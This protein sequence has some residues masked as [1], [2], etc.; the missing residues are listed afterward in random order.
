MTYS[1]LEGEGSTLIYISDPMCSWCYGFA[2][3]ISEIKEAYPQYDFK[4]ILGG[5]RPGGTETNKDLGSFLDHHWK[6]VE[7]RTW[8]KVQLRHSERRFTGVRHRAILTGGGRCPQDETG[9]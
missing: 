1:W 3:E 6:E 5:L 7:K 8:Q 9:N 2:P 4:V